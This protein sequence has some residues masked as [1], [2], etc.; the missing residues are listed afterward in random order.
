V[1]TVG[2]TFCRNATLCGFVEGWPTAQLL[3]YTHSY[4]KD[5]RLQETTEI[6]PVQSTDWIKGTRGST[7]SFCQQ[8]DE[9]SASMRNTKFQSLNDYWFLK[10]N[11]S[12]TQ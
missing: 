8:G 9:P 2:T 7:V 12:W 10:N 5:I 6:Y 3:R 11:A 4:P 1:A